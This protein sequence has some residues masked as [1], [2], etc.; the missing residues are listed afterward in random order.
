MELF[1]V[2]YDGENGDLFGISIV[3]D[4]ANGFDFI[5]MSKKQVIKLSSDE[6]K[7][8]LYGIVLRPEQKIY[9]EFEDGTPFQLMFDAPTIERFSQ[10]FMMKGYQK[11]STFNHDHNNWLDGTTVVENWI[12][13]NKENDKASEIGLPVENGDWVIGMKLSD[14]LWSEYIET[15]KAKGFSI[16][17]FIE[18][19]KIN[20]RKVTCDDCL[21]QELKEDSRENNKKETMSMLKKL[22]N[23]LSNEGQVS[24]ASLETDLGTFTADAFELGNIVY[25]AEL[26]PVLDAE[27][28]ADN[29]V[30]KTDATG[31]I[32]E[33][34]DIV[35]EEG[36][37][38]EGDLKKKEDVAME[39][40]EPA[41]VEEVAVV[42]EDIVAEVEKPIEEVD[43]EALKAKI[44]ALTAELEKITAQQEAVLMENVELKNMAAS[45]KLKAEVKGQSPI[46]MK[47]K[48]KSDD[49]ILSAIE[50]ITKKNK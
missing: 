5:A 23:F 47:A 46:T 4:P 42:T 9:R 20:M 8:I 29:K 30:Y 36:D 34:S 19:E 41:I 45:T 10:D 33:I 18:F 11:N 21:T 44:E 2:K 13:M 50:R 24:L 48:E 22:I 12:V 37:Q 26:N 38:M 7:K 39:D 28:K 32:V 1:R 16:D 35:E 43:V 25:D 15:G 17:S 27:F 14:E 49:S 6:K 3:D 40:V 31:A